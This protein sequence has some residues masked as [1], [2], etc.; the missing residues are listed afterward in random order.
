MHGPPNRL[1]ALLACSPCWWCCRLGRRRQQY[2]R[3]GHATPACHLA[4]LLPRG[5]QPT[6]W[7]S[8]GDTIVISA[9]STSLATLIGVAL[10][11][12]LVRTNMPGARLLERLAILPIFIPPFVGAFAWV[13]LAAP[14]IGL[15]ISACVSSA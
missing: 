7:R 1:I 12:T 6:Y 11:W 10:A 14:R 5:P 8:L 15:A 2:I 9:G 4:E 3:R 13:L